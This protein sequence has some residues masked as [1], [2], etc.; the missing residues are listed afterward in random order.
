[1]NDT[2]KKA[3]TFQREERYIVIKINDLKETSLGMYLEEHI[4]AFLKQYGV[5]PRECVVIERDWP[6]Y[7]PAWRMIQDRMEGRANADAQREG[8]AVGTIKQAKDGHVFADLDFDVLREHVGEKLY[9]A[10]PHPRAVMEAAMKLVGIVRAQCGGYQ[11]G[12][13]KE[14]LDAAIALET[15]LSE[16]KV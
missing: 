6:E 12:P 9:T 16:G 11:S 13:G 2:T 14:A 15:A 4:R 1:M 3:M 8:E 7:E 10:P 5:S